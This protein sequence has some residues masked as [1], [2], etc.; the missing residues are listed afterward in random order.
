MQNF[1]SFVMNDEIRLPAGDG[2]SAFVDHRDVSAAGVMAL[3]ESGHEGQ[4][5]PLATESLSHHEI[6]A[7]LS[8]AT[9]RSITY[10]AI[11]AETYQR[12][13][14]ADGWTPEGIESVQCLY[15]DIRAETNSDSDID[16]LVASVLG[17]PGIRFCQYAADF[18]DRYGT[19]C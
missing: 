6:A 4:D 19:G 9:G 11:S 16:D 14:E 3:T 12:E 15:S 18:A 13:L 10:S 5:Y 8:E 1:E 17:R 7:Q 2:R